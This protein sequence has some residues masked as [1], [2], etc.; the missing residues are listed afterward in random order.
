MRQ[1]EY[2]PAL[3]TISK[4]FPQIDNLQL[5]ILKENHQEILKTLEPIYLTFIDILQFKEHIG[6]VFHQI[7]EW[8]SIIWVKLK[9]IK[10]RLIDI[11]RPAVYVHEYFDEFS[12]YK[13]I[14][15]PCHELYQIGFV[16]FACWR[17]K[18]CYWSLQESF[19]LRV[20]WNSYRFSGYLMAH[21]S[22]P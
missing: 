22:Y 18:S 11:N 19:N 10:S 13:R 12:Y 1:R 4:K 2:Q 14:L 15:D 20:V 17:Q 8:I 9:P 3:Q 6:M 5:P 21:M 16:T 7:M